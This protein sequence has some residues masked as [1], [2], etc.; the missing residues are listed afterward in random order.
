MSPK[1]DFA[2]PTYIQLIRWTQKGIENVK[3]S[4]ARL[5]AARK[6]AESVGGKI[7]DTYLVMGRYDLVLV[8]EA[9]DD[10][11]MAKVSLAL[12]SKGNITTETLKAFSEAEYR[13]ICSSLP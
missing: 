9:T 13:K 3:D 7:K 10:A 1:G 5:D 8:T 6:V 2:M 12:A 11:A 4:P